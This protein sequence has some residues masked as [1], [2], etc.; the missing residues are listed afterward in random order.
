MKMSLKYISISHET[1]SIIQREN[2]HVSDEEKG[3][4]I[5]SI[6]NTFDDIIGLLI[7]ST[8]NRTEIYF[9][10]SLTSAAVIRDFFIKIKKDNIHANKALFN[11]SNNTKNTVRHLLTVSSGLKSLVLGDAEIIHQIKKAYQFS[12]TF[13]VQGSLL[14]RALQSAFKNHKRISNETNFRDGTTSVAY[15]ALNFIK[16]SYHNE[17]S[18]KSK[19]ILLIGAGDIVHQILKYNTKFK[20]SN[21]YLSNRT[22]K[23]AKVLSHRYQCQLYPWKK[24]ISNDI[25]DFD[26]IISAVN[27]CHHLIKKTCTNKEM[28]LLDLAIPGNIDEALSKKKNITYLDLDT[29]SIELENTRKNRLTSINKVK[30]ITSQELLNFVKWHNK[31]SLR[32]L[33]SKHKSTVLEKVKR[34]FMSTSERISNDKIVA[35]SNQIM[36]KFLAPNNLDKT[37][38]NLDKIISK[39]ITF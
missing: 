22:E 32:Q 35:I 6:C 29:I 2:F 20:F 39:E 27:N 19:K 34:H 36:K 21:L 28:L 30:E 7:L 16:N 13:K 5:H 12:M 38:T 33:L 9:E 3:I 8:C 24:V 11:F 15:K 4:L 23:K 1:A 37:L 10:S 25:K 31:L 26:I 17:L 18:V 14:E